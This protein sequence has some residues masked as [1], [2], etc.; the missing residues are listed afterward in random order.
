[1]AIGTLV[2][3]VQQ[4]L[5]GAPEM[6]ITG[7]GSYGS[8]LNWFADRSG[9]PLPTG[10]VLSL[11]VWVYRL[12]MLAWALWLALACLRWV[13]WAWG[14]YATG[15]FWHPAPKVEPLRKPPPIPASAP[16][17]PQGP[18]PTPP[19]PGAPKP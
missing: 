19:P 10:F 1:V 9:G 16:A 12:A 17:S 2:G 3:A 18:A 13:T 6:Q 7:Y 15:G 11:P 5:L 4:G 8:Q 14:S